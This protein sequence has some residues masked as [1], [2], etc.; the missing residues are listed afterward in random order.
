VEGLVIYCFVVG[1]DVEL[2]FEGQHIESN[3]FVLVSFNVIEER[4]E[5]G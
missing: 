4:L 2:G 3:V 1:L 5:A